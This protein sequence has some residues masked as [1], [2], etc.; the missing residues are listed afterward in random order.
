MEAIVYLQAVQKRLVFE[1]TVKERRK[2]FPAKV[3]P[4]KEEKHDISLRICEGIQNRNSD[5]TPEFL[6]SVIGSF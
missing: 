1:R 2:S 3:W 6:L 4:K 5:N